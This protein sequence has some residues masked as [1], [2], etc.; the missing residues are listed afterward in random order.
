MRSSQ[1]RQSSRTL[2]LSLADPTPLY[3]TYTFRTIDLRVSRSIFRRLLY[4]VPLKGWNIIWVPSAVGFRILALAVPSLSKVSVTP[5]W[6][7]RH[8][9]EALNVSIVSLSAAVGLS[10]IDRQG[11]G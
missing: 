6:K 4:P 10:G 7:S 8:I 11:R 3:F 2:R 5:T 9:N 1:F